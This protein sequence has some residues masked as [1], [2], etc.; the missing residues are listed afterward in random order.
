MKTLRCQTGAAAWRSRSPLPLERLNN[1]SY[2]QSAQRACAHTTSTP[3][4]GST[5]ILGQLQISPAVAQRLRVEKVR[6]RSTDRVNQTSQSELFAPWVCHTTLMRPMTIDNKL[7]IYRGTGVI[8]N[9]FRTE[10]LTP[11]STERL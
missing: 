8:G 9:D 5:A 4:A 1:T 10:N 7:R 6:P 3:P 11:P 2:S